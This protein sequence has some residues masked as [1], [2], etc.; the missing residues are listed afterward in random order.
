MFLRLPHDFPVMDAQR[1]HFVLDQ[2]FHLYMV[3]VAFF[4]AVNLLF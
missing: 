1:L 2:L 3:R 4:F